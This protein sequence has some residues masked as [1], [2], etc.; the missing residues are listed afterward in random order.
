MPM[1]RLLLALLLVTAGQ[2]ALAANPPAP[3]PTGPRRFLAV[4]KWYGTYTITLHAQSGRD[5]QHQIPND[6]GPPT[7]ETF[8]GNVEFNYRTTFTFEFDE[9]Q[10]TEDDPVPSAIDWAG[11]ASADHRSTVETNTRFTQDS[12]GGLS[13]TTAWAKATT[14]GRAERPT[15]PNKPKVEDD[16]PDLEC[17][18]GHIRIDVK[19]GTYDFD[20]GPPRKQATIGSESREETRAGDDVTH[21]ETPY[22]EAGTLPIGYS[23]DARA[24]R[25]PILIGPV[26]PKQR[27]PTTVADAQAML[28]ANMLEKDRY[29][30]PKDGMVITGSDRVDYL[31]VRMN[32]PW[33]KDIVTIPVTMDISW[34]FT[35]YKMKL[36]LAP[37]DEATYKNWLPLPIDQPRSYDNAERLTFKATLKPVPGSPAE[38]DIIHFR[39]T[40]VTKYRGICLNDPPYTPTPAPEKEDV[41]FA[42]QDQQPNNIRRISDTE[43]ETTDKV[44][45]ATVV[46]E[47]YDTAAFGKLRADCQGIVG[48]YAGKEFIAIPRDDNDNKIADTWD[49]DYSSASATADNEAVPG[50]TKKGDGMSLL[51]EYRGY[52]VLKQPGDTTPKHLRTSGKEKDLFFFV[53]SCEV[54]PK[55]PVDPD[56]FYALTKIRPHQVKAPNV[57]RGAGQKESRIVNY[58][59]DGPFLFSLKIVEL[60]TP[61]DPNLA[62]L[63]EADLA[64]TNGALGYTADLGS[65]QKAD[66]CFIFPARATAHVAGRMELLDE[67]LKNPNTHWPTPTS[68]TLKARL[69]ELSPQ[70]YVMAPQAVAA[71]KANPNALQQA[72]KTDAMLIVGAHEMAHACGASHHGN[73]STEQW[74][75][76]K[77]CM[78]RYFTIAEDWESMIRM[79][80]VPNYSMVGPFYTNLCRGSQWKCF[81]NLTTYP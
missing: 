38:K 39:L 25:F 13:V 51:D 22:T 53:E 35:P 58:W 76:P 60:A 16:N 64:Q 18:T 40:N 73:N 65:P 70:A 72:W 69:D 33:E 12:G 20:F 30:L 79:A 67:A 1:P 48:T 43:C 62:R 81:E 45:E 3:Q 6:N 66:G 46:V 78:M 8:K 41:R 80:M 7:H 5:V 24:F 50:Q 17:G 29:T 59:T 31:H 23:V 19:K 27:T 15:G 74:M 36:E 9:R 75:D 61:G 10:V 4:Q 42:P 32:A 47:A 44:S 34:T 49:K 54:G 14:K 71:Y 11:F 21:S 26:A 52:L 37:A 57:G 2:L 68:R 63:N 77:L 28:A 56:W 55:K